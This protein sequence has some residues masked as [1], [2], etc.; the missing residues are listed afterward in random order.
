M[1]NQIQNCQ[2][3]IRISS[4]NPTFNLEAVVKRYLDS[5]VESLNKKK[6]VYNTYKS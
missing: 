3:N 4:L 1:K 2:Q 6:N 5:K